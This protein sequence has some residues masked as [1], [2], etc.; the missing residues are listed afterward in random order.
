MALRNIFLHNFRWKITALLLATLFWL[1][2]KFTIASGRNQR[3]PHQPV[4]ALKAA[5]DPRVFRI[6]PPQVD[7]VVQSVREMR[8]QDVVVFVDLTTMP[9]V[10]GTFKEVL[11]R[12]PE[13]TRLVR[14]EPSRLVKIE[15]IAPELPAMT[16]SLYH[17]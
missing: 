5:D 15:R 1:V 4:M 11:V 8:D 6:H 2:I 7:V 13:G 9:D 17:Q 16:N 12:A 10:S 3:L 14:V